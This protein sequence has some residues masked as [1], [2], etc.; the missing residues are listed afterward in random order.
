MHSRR[1]IVEFGV[2]AVVAIA[3]P[4]SVAL[5]QGTTGSPPGAPTAAPPTADM[6]R[7]KD[8]IDRDVYTSDNVEVGEIEDLILDG[9]GRIVTAVIELEGRLGFTEKYVA[10]PFAQLRPDRGQRR[11]HLTMTRDEVRALPGFEYRD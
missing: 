11:V 9:Q 3:A 10:V 4:A 5:A 7:V 1:N 6:P 8:L 2:A